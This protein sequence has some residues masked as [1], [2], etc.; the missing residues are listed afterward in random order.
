MNKSAAA[1]WVA[2]KGKKDLYN[3]AGWDL[4]DAFERD[5]LVTA[6]IDVKTLPDNLQKKSRAEIIGFVKEKNSQRG[7]IEKEISSTN[8]KRE[9]Y[10]AAEKKK[11]VTNTGNSATLETEIEK[12]IKKQAIR[13]NMIIESN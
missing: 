1:K 8:A 4:V 10:I 13:F 11:S 7:K 3:N 2:V 9:I 5:S 12:I 6:K